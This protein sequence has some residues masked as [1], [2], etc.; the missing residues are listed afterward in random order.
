MPSEVEFLENDRDNPVERSTDAV[1]QTSKNATK[2]SMTLIIVRNKRSLASAT[3]R[4]SPGPAGSDRRH[5]L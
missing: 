5:A 2:V 3:F 1:L 4:H